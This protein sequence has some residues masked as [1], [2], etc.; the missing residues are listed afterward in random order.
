MNLKTLK[1][2]DDYYT[3]PSNGFKNAK[4]YYTQ[5]S[6]KPFISKIKR[7]TLIINA[8]DDPF[9]TA[10]SMPIEE[11]GGNDFVTF[12][13]PKHGGHVGFCRS[14]KAKIY[15]HEKQILNFLEQ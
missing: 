12:L 10:E 6:S 8:A 14:V 11:S 1:A 3:A 15:W 13:N 4:D 2:F 7:E 5:S 9:L